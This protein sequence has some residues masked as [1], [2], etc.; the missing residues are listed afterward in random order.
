MLRIIEETFKND[1]TYKIIEFVGAGTG[2]FVVKALH[3]RLNKEVVLK[4]IKDEDGGFSLEYRR[5]ETDLLKTLKHSY[6]PQVLDF[7][8]REV[9]VKVNIKN[10]DEIEVEV[11]VIAKDGVKVAGKDEEKDAVKAEEGVKRIK[12]YFTVMDFISGSD[13]SKVAE[14]GRKFRYKEIVNIG[15]QLCEAVEYLHNCKPPII[16]SDIKP[17][18]VMLNKNGDICLIDFNVSLV[19]DK[20]STVIGGTPGYAPPEQLGIPLSTIRAGISGKLPVGQVQ[21]AI[22]E[23][24]DIYSI[25]A[26]LYFMVTG[27]TPACNYKVV[28]IDAAKYKVSDGLVH[29][30][31]KAMALEPSKRYK[32]VSEMLYALRNIGKLDKR[33]KALKI[34]RI[35]VT[36]AAAVLMFACASMSRLGSKRLVEER[37][38]KYLGYVSK[39]SENVEHG[40]YSAAKELIEKA[41][42]LEPSRIDPYYNTEKIMY[43]NNEYEECMAYPDTVLIPEVMVNSKNPWNIRSEMFEMAADS[44]F[45]LEEYAKAVT[46]YEKTLFFN[47]TITDCYRDLCISYARS[48]DI[49]RAE[50]SLKR[51]KDNNVSDDSIELMQGEISVA[52]GD[53]AAAYESFNN[54]IKLTENDYVR[55]R[56]LLACDN[57]AAAEEENSG[58][59]TLK[60][61]EMISG[62]IDNVAEEYST[63]VTE[64]LAGD[65]AK[66][67]ELSGDTEYYEKAAECYGKLLDNDKLGYSL[68]KNYFNILFSKLKSYDKCDPLLD[69]MSAVNPGDYWVEMSRSYL[70][71]SIENGISDHLKRDYSKAYASYLKAVEQYK[72]F[73]QNGKTDPNM[74]SLT[75]AINELRSFGWI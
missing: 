49:P 52:K 13:L 33:Y 23:R 54:A 19:F 60:M 75:S 74:D 37:E 47:D 9:K 39:I 15:V 73:T 38:E 30:I 12:L 63:T 43:A 24:S 17:G 50:Y 16:H 55:F 53:F 48:G 1:D 72:I 18:N 62:Q 69:K 64:M 58:E 26:S 7:I 32:N 20:N 8:E 42:Q 2:G 41:S 57:A 65:C 51:A 44:A 29:I 27:E 22:S 14:D 6:L 40:E 25:G 59:V 70:Y 56:A 4:Q 71:I 3:T 61:I 68:M 36:A 46:L 5:A 21:L 10:E 34:R 35:A 31:A 66:Y 67:A 11:E 45:E 28:P